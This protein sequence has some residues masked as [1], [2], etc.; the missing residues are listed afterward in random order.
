[1]EFC[2]ILNVQRC[3]T[4]NI[5]YKILLVFLI[6]NITS[7]YMDQNPVLSVLSLPDFQ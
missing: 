7:S 4:Y 1:M 6:T 3:I 5:T 2:P